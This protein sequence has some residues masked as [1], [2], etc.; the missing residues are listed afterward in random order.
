MLQILIVDDTPIARMGTT[1]LVRELGYRAD[2][3]CDGIEALEKFK[4]ASYALVLIDYQMPRM[5][6][7][8]CAKKMREAETGSSKRTPIVCMSTSV[9]LKKLCHESGVDDYVSK[10]C[11]RQ[12]LESIISRLCS[13]C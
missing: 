9:D 11:S 3:A 8:E 5:N 12:E 13:E 10:D 2:E 1:L 6:G 7:I 4:A